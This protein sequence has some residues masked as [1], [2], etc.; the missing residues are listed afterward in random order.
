MRLEKKTTTTR[1]TWMV[2][3]S[4]IHFY[5]QECRVIRHV[6]CRWTTRHLS[7]TG[8]IRCNCPNVKSKK[9]KRDFFFFHKISI[10]FWNNNNKK[11]RWRYYSRGSQVTG[12][13]KEKKQNHTSRYIFRINPRSKQN[14][15]RLR[16]K[17]V[18]VFFF[19]KKYT[20]LLLS[21]KFR[22]EEE[23]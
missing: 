12:P 1:K 10:Q 13:E 20:R 4:S 18:F 9:N 19:F 23:T 11:K 5:A 14:E 17:Q 7:L 16:A 6:T 3:S 15:T 22:G 21:R 2:V 8:Q